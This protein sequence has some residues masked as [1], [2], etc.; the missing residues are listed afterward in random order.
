MKNG[1]LK[2]ELIRNNYREPLRG[3]ADLMRDD[4]VDEGRRC[5]GALRARGGGRGGRRRGRRAARP[6]ADTGGYTLL[7]LIQHYSSESRPQVVDSNPDN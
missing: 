6:P 4:G 7:L 1:I 2:E 3:L 5:E